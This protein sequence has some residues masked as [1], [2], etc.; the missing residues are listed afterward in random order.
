[1]QTLSVRKGGLCLP[2]RKLGTRE[3]KELEKYHSPRRAAASSPAGARAS[4]T[5]FN[6]RLKRSG[7]QAGGWPE[8][9]E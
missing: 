2:W 8:T 1:M 9:K 6:A 7:R 5:A 4:S 3:W